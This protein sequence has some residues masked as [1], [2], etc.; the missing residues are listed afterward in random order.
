MTSLKTDIFIYN[1]V[2]HFIQDGKFWKMRFGKKLN[3]KKK[4]FY[5]LQK[6]VNERESV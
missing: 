2:E 4:E 1:G 6:K 5:K 3:V